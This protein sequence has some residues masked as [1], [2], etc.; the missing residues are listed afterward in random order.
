MHMR[1]DAHQHFWTPPLLEALAARASLPYVRRGDGV[2]VLHCAGERPYV[3]DVSSETPMRRAQLLQT[4]GVD[5]A[6]IA[7]SSP[8]GIEALARESATALIEAHLDGVDALGNEFVPWGPVALDQPDPDDIDRLLARGCVG[9]SLPAGAL[10][11][12]D[13]LTAVGSL[14]DR[15]AA[16]Q[17]PVFVHPGH[18]PWQRPPETSLTEPLWWRAMTGYVAQMQ[19]AWLTFATRGRREHP[20][21]VVVFAMLAGGAPLH[22]ERLAARGGPPVEL[23]D[24]SVFYDTSSYAPIAIQ[25]MARLVGAA[26][27]VYGSDRPVVQPV[28]TGQEAWLQANAAG[29]LAPVGSRA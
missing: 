10:A 21:L 12:P 24:P 22:S 25:A 9:V 14:L 26:Q 16:C 2:T 4:D 5:L 20:E 7:L 15:S 23:R 1:V 13:A 19:E 27:L 11:G 28:P 29:L 3:I 18:T 17:V 8:V 6:L